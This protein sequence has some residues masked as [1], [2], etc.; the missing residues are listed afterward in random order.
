MSIAIHFDQSLAEITSRRRGAAGVL[1][2]LG[3]DYACRGEWSLAEACR[4]RGIDPGGRGRC[5][6]KHASP[7][8]ASR[9]GLIARPVR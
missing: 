5:S 7:K 4:D 1:Q 9:R 2:R 6:S 8:R 3:L